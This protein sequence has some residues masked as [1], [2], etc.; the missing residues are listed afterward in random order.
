MQSQFSDEMLQRIRRVGVIAVLVV[1]EVDHAVPLAKALLAGGIDVM[2]LT[3]R[4][5]A[6]LN[7]LKE[8][9]KHVPDMLAGIGTVLTARQVDEAVEAGAAFGLAPGLNRGVVERAQKQGLPFAPGVLT[10]SDIES[11]IELGCRELKFFPAES[12]GGLKLLASIQAPYAHLGLKFLPLG[13]LNPDNMSSYLVD[14]TI[15][16]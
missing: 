12:V 4:T 1:D 10:P 7:C 3:L 16:A 5:P 6:A 14:P 9:R 8:I 15:L 2:E 11:A 13:G